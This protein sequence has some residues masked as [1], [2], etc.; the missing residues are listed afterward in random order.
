[1]VSISACMCKLNKAFGA[2]GFRFLCH[3]ECESEF[4]KPDAEKTIIF[5]LGLKI[6]ILLIIIIP[7]KSSS[8]SNRSSSMGRASRCAQDHPCF[9][10]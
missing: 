7:S 8:C 4:Y 6:A 5:F 9:V 2:A 1:M 3:N 10:I